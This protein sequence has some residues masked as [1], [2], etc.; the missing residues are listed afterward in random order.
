[1]E[2]ASALTSIINSYSN[3]LPSAVAVGPSASQVATLIL[4]YV[5]M[6]PLKVGSHP[7]I[8]FKRQELWSA[9]PHSSISGMSTEKLIDSASPQFISV[10]V[11]WSS[12]V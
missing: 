8:S 12:P 10:R 9:E 2:P 11:P 5:T 6:S 1:M 4:E 3:L 7:A